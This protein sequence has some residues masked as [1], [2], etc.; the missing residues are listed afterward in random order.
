[1]NNLHEVHF[2][3]YDDAMYQAY[4]DVLDSYVKDG[5]LTLSSAQGT[6]VPDLSTATV[7]NIATDPTS[8]SNAVDTTG[9]VVN[10]ITSAKAQLKRCC[11]LLWWW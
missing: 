10:A 4:K 3:G 2:Y 8:T 11:P 9:T 6:G 1:M 5:K 7:V